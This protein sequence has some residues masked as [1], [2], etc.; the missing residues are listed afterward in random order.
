M[1][2]MTTIKKGIEF[3]VRNLFTSN[4]AP[5]YY[6][7]SGFPFEPHC[8]GAALKTLCVLSEHHG[9]ELYNLAV[10]TARWT[11]ANLYNEKK[12]YFYYQKKRWFLNKIDYLRWSQ[13]W[14]FVGLS[15]LVSYGK[16]H[17]YTFD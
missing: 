10:R 11:I 13:A 12:G 3:Y 16:K 14:M 1:G 7:N 5:K 6:K 8:S 15:Y 4:S 17:G 9:I 2:V